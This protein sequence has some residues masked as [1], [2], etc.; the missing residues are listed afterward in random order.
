M[1]NFLMFFG[2]ALLFIGLPTSIILTIV[3]TVKKNKK[4]IFSAVGIPVSFILSLILLG[5]GGYLYG[6]TDEYKERLAQQEIERQ[7]RE[8]QERIE[9]ERK[10]E[11]EKARLESEQKEK[12]E[13]ESTEEKEESSQNNNNEEGNERKTEKYEEK[14][15]DFFEGEE[16]RLVKSDYLY[17][18]SEFYSRETICTV[19]SINDFSGKTVYTYLYEDNNFS[20]Y[21]RF[22]SKK[23]IKNLKEGD[24]ICVAGTV[25]EGQKTGKVVDLEDCHIIAVGN[26]TEDVYDR[27]IKDEDSQIEFATNKKSEKAEEAIQM[28]DKYKKNFYIACESCGIDVLE[29]KNY[30][31]LPNWENGERYS[32]EYGGNI[33]NAYLLD[34]G[35]I[36][37]INYC[38]S[39]YVKLYEKGYEPLNI[40][41]FSI[42]IGI[43]STM[44]VAAESVVKQSLNYP[45]SAN[46]D[47]WTTGSYSRV[48]DY[49]ILRAEFSAK[50]AFG[51]K[52][53]HSFRIDCTY[54]EENGSSLVYYELDGVAQVGEPNIPEIIKVPIEN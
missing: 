11:E 33:H 32:F 45:S 49:Y 21:C 17:A 9:A 51:M 22:D 18:N 40:D 19:L 16:V 31:K 24:K 8:E 36:E 42:D 37:S 52:D 10:A 23:E 3:F 6:Q 41:D 5:I 50:N 46:F 15:N 2:I 4:I 12:E 43:L 47:W 28:E 20:V 29:I 39:T 48:Y 38:Q 30:E 14:I 27:I 7:E 26:E 25:K 54:S 53:R 34:N 1:I 35:D 44:Q 13:Q